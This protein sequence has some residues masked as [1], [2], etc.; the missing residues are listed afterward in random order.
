MHL[1]EMADFL[2]QEMLLLALAL[3]KPKNA[4]F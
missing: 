3:I 2:T 1:K 4:I